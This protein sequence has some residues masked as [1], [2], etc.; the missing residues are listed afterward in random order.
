MRVLVA[1]GAGYVGS[2]ACKAL[3]EAGYEPVTY[4]NLVFGHA[5]AVK[6]GPLEIGDVLDAERLDE[7]FTR[8][9]PDVVMHFAAF[10]YVGES[11]TDPSKYYRNNITGSI[12]LLDAMRRNGVDKIVFSSTCATYGVPE[13]LPISED[14]PQAPINPYGYTKLVVERALADYE[15]AYG[16]KWAAMRYFNA[17]GCDPDGE[18]GERHDPETHAIPLAIHAA[19]GSGPRFSVFGT[20]YATPDGSAIRDYVHVCDLATAHVKAI[21]HL[22]NGG[23]SRAYNLATGRGTSVIE[24]LKSVEKA[25]GRPVPADYAPRRAGDPPALFAVAEAA[26]RILDWSPRYTDIDE[27]VATA[28]N[29]FMRRHNA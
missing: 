25:V 5:D 17:A 24:L 13:T 15:R 21:P 6:W 7:V 12:A 3:A 29:W 19:L 8:H 27:T 28:A 4:D 14:T 2:H 20:D 1:G 23:E 11:V 18:L 9:R 16:V 26:N 10:A 22:A